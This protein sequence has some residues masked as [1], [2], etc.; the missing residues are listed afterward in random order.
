MTVFDDLS[1]RLTL[2]RPVWL[3]LMFDFLL[4]FFVCYRTPR[5]LS[6]RREMV[7]DSIPRRR[8]NHV[9]ASRPIDRSCYPMNS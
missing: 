9:S 6:Q 3:I 1:M 5:S 8:R 4:R 7:E 2:S